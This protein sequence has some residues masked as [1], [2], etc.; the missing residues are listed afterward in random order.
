MVAALV[1][2]VLVALEHMLEPHFVT[3]TVW[4]LWWP[5]VVLVHGCFGGGGGGSGAG[6]ADKVKQKRGGNG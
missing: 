2:V 1:G 3:C 5:V 4:W 6:R